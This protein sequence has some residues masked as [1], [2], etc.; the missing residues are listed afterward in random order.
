MSLAVQARAIGHYLDQPN[1]VRAYSKVA[2][3]TGLAGLGALMGY[4]TWKATPQARKQT[5]IR[6]GIVLGATALGT[7]AAASVLMRP[8]AK[9]LIDYEMKAL[10]QKLT[11]YKE[12]YPAIKNWL[13]S[14]PFHLKKQLQVGD[15]KTLIKGIQ[16]HSALSSKLRQQHLNDIFPL[17]DSEPLQ[18]E[19]G[20]QLPKAIWK[21]LTKV[22]LKGDM[23]ERTG[24]V[25]K[26]LNF[27]ATGLA[28]VVSGLLGGMAANKVNRVTD[29][30]A[31]V[32]MCKEGIFQFIAN[33]ALCA[34]GASAGLVAVELPVVHKGLQALGPVGARLGKFGIIGAGLSVGIVGGGKIA[35][36]LGETVVNPMFDKMQGKAPDPYEKPEKRR[37]EFADAILHLDDLP[38]ALAL[39]GMEIMEPFIPIFF[40]FSGYRTGIGYR[41]NDSEKAAEKKSAVAGGVAETPFPFRD[42][43]PLLMQAV[44][45]PATG[46]SRFAA[47]S[48][49]AAQKAPLVWA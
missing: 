37:V 39:A 40:A 45:A 2:G 11:E 19:N 20:F 49:S 42:F 12:T 5:V 14:S 27:F 30:D 16:E 4:D 23:Q 41:N 18:Y 28:S 46:P 47:A 48:A 1:V 34:V 36:R 22:E 44:S 24:E 17:G 43:T 6:D 32:N 29:P 35:N 21:K 8:P 13:A 7:V 9:K 33:I 26:M 15:F 38:T 3:L 25:W 10:G 31:T